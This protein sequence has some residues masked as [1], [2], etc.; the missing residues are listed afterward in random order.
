MAMAHTIIKPLTIQHV[1]TQVDACSKAAPDALLLLKLLSQH[2]STHGQAMHQSM[3]LSIQNTRTIR[4][5]IGH[6]FEECMIV[7]PEHGPLC[8]ALHVID[9]VWPSPCSSLSVIAVA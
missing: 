3:L 5:C 4:Q 2:M 9:I 1:L 8:S 6:K 7:G